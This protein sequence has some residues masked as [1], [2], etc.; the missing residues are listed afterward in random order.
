MSSMSFLNASNV[1]IYSWANS[2]QL[3]DASYELASRN[4]AYTHRCPHCFESDR[5][6]HANS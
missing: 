4:L 2:M 3:R 1:F 6:Q 5:D